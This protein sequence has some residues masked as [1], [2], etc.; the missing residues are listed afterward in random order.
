MIDEFSNHQIL[1]L[2][3]NND[4]IKDYYNDFVGY[5]T[6]SGVN[7]RIFALYKKM[8]SL[9]L[10]SSSNILELGCGIGVMTKLL[11]TFVTTG[12]IE[13]VDL[14]DKSVEFAK[15]NVTKKNVSFCIDDVV[16]YTPKKN[17]FD[18]ITLFDVIEHIPL[19]LHANLFKN[20]SKIVDDKTKIL[21]NI[22][23]PEF[24]TFHQKDED[25][26]LQIVDQPVPLQL[27]VKNAE[28]NGLQVTNFNTYSIWV[29]SD[30]QFFIIQ[31]KQAYKKFL[32]SEKRTIA[33]KISNKLKNIF[34]NLRY[35]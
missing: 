31:K 12:N 7:E 25:A 27:I 2:S 26:W 19:E 22:P 11:S 20:L 21:I 4:K 32:L 16:N 10:K 3:M 18:F 29:E 1:T 35:N 24:I 34:I 13:S 33:E 28:D 6:K 5:Q 8:R 30:Y 14:S 17:N 23:N 15:K 9:G